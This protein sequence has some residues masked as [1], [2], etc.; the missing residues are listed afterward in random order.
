MAQ[1]QQAGT[2]QREDWMVCFA[3]EVVLY[4]KACQKYVEDIIRL[5][6]SYQAHGE[7]AR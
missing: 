5:R 4:E 1:D 2:D 6:N 3:Q 7:E